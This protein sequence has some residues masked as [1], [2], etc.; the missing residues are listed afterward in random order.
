MIQEN[1]K[2]V[3]KVLKKELAKDQW[4]SLD[5]LSQKTN[6]SIDA[7]L[8][9][10]GEVLKENNEVGYLDGRFVVF[11]FDLLLSGYE[12]LNNLM[13]A[14]DQKIFANDSFELKAD[15]EQSFEYCS[16]LLSGYQLLNEIE[17]LE[18]V[19]AKKDYLIEEKKQ[20]FGS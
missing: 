10:K 4:I 8:K 19:M 13:N 18:S 16:F 12:F 7:I 2:N 3:L 17:Y 11:S 5:D 15:F 14:I 9:I 20:V 6:I 1:V